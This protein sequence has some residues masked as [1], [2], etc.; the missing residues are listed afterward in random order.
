M[1]KKTTVLIVLLAL[2]TV[3][4]VFFAISSGT[5]QQ[6][7][8]TTPETDTPDVAIEKTTT[9]YFD[10]PTVEVSP[11]NESPIYAVDIMINTEGAAVSGV[12]TELQYDISS[13]TNVRLDPAAGSDGLFGATS[14]VLFNDVNPTTGRVSYAV[15]IGQGQ[16]SIV[17]TG[18]IATLYFE[19]TLGSSGTSTIDFL[20][21]T[22]VTM[23]GENES[24]MKEALP[25]NIIFTNPA[26]QQEFIA[27][28]IDLPA[29]SLPESQPQ[30]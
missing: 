30:E 28:P 26:P 29:T 16:E 22:L 7:T 15:S 19:P 20:N 2:V 25:L 6:T 8:D 17:G 11:A 5:G 1:P 13:I 18:R 10:P 23:L 12:Q 9:V 27:P 4:L 14:V 24:V 21:K 3:V